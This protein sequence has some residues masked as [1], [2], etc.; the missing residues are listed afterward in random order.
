MFSE[1]AFSAA[2]FSAL[3]AA[4]ATDWVPVNDLSSVAWIPISDAGTAWTPVSTNTTPWTPVV[5]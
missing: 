5:A 1:S 2:A 3:T 4:L